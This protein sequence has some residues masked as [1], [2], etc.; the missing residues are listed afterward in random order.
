MK[1]EYYQQYYQWVKTHWWFRARRKIILNILKQ[2]K[3]KKSSLS[4]LNI[5]CADTLQDIQEL[6]L[7]NRWF[8][9][10]IDYNTVVHSRSKTTFSIQGDAQHLPF[11]DNSFHI[12]FLLDIL[13]HINHD[14]IALQEATRV[15]RPSGHI[16]ITV[17]AH[18]WLWGPQDEISQH[19]RRYQKKELIQLINKHSL[20]IKKLTYFNTFLF[21]FIAI[22]RIFYKIKKPQTLRSDFE[23]NNS[24]FNS[25]F[26]QIFCCEKFI[27]T[28]LNFPF[29]TSLLSLCQK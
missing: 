13:E 3:L 29:G 18:R 19:Y 14:E 28:K 24:F 4:I 8:N 12:V 20:T 21:P 1:K 25:L 5:G 6:F 22:T 15:C 17:P 23:L 10:D 7:S 26:Y 9:L 2:F 11:R 16:I 27:L